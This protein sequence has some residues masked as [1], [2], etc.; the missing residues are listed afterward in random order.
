MW[1]KVSIFYRRFALQSSLCRWSACFT[2]FFPKH[3]HAVSL[4]LIMLLPQDI[5]LLF[6]IWN[7]ICICNLS[8]ITK[9]PV[10]AIK[11]LQHFSQ[12]ICASWYWLFYWR[13]LSKNDSRWVFQ[14]E[15]NKQEKYVRVTYRDVE[16]N[17]E[18]RECDWSLRLNT[19]KTYLHREVY[20]FPTDKRS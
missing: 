8:E 12:L 14:S 7:L 18:S 5:M 19:S 20:S 4:L 9:F 11:E 3:H 2:S 16:K 10:W 1:E 17:Q 15:E 13:Q 6:I